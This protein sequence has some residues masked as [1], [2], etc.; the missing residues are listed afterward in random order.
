MHYSRSSQANTDKNREKNYIYVIELQ[1][2]IHII[3]NFMQLLYIH[4]HIPAD[5]YVYN[6]Q[7]YTYTQSVM[8][9]SVFKQNSYW[10]I[11][12]LHHPSV[13]QLARH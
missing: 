4:M 8:P 3:H 13:Y 2:T 9:I 7:I 6:T 11:S 12:S 10:G 1:I 5:L